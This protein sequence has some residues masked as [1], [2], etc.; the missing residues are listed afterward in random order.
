LWSRRQCALAAAATVRLAP[1]AQLPPQPQDDSLSFTPAPVLYAK[2]EICFFTRRLPQLGQVMPFMSF[3]LRMIFSKRSPHLTQRYS[4][5]AM[6]PV[7][8]CP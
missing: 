7:Y 4:Y 6:R 5:M 8:F 3:G 2:R 1:H